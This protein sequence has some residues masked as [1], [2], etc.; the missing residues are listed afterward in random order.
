MSR[1]GAISVFASLMMIASCDGGQV[2]GGVERPDLGFAVLEASQAT[3]S[4]R[5]PQ[6]IYQQCAKQPPVVEPM[7]QNWFC[8]FAIQTNESVQD[9]SA[10]LSVH[11]DD[12]VGIWKPET[13]LNPSSG[14]V[15]STLVCKARD[16]KM[17]S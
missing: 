5:V 9:C 14:D 4:G 2:L 11:P 16:R 15:E 3:E 8:R 12:H 10:T 7:N 17:E 1:Q 13:R 6:L